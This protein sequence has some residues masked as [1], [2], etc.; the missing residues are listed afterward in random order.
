MKGFILFT[1][2]AAA[3][4]TYKARIPNPDGIE[5]VNAMGHIDRINGGG[6]RNTFGL[7]FAAN[8]KSWNK[9]FCN[10]DSDGDGKTNGQ[11]LG[12]PCCE[13]IP[14]NDEILITSDLSHPGDAQD[15]STSAA[16]SCTPS[17]G[18]TEKPSETSTTETPTPAPSSAT[19]PT[20]GFF[21]TIFLNLVAFY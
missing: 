19:M 13:W 14:G 7:D 21:L 1:A 4:S 3:Y 16:V 18:P 10:L 5:G 20:F 11:E 17:T 6:P 8:G 12:D 15:V 2:T 9:V